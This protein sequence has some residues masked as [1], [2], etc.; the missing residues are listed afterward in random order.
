MAFKS[1]VKDTFGLLA[2][3][4]HTTFLM[5]NRWNLI[6]LLSV[7]SAVLSGEGDDRARGVDVLFRLG[8]MPQSRAGNLHVRTSSPSAPHTTLPSSSNLP[9]PGYGVMLDS[10][11]LYEASTKSLIPSEIGEDFSFV[12]S[13]SSWRANNAFLF[14]I[15]DGRD[16][17]R[18]GVQLLPRRVVVH[19]AE[20][21][22]YF[23]YNWQDG[24][25][26]ALGVRAHSV[27]FYAECGAVQQR[28]QT[29]R[30]AQML[31]ESG[32]LFTLGRMN[33]KSPAFSGRLCQLDIYPS[34]QAAA[35]YCNY[36]KTQCR[37]ADTYRL[38]HPGLNMEA[39][40]P[41]FDPLPHPEDQTS[42]AI[43][44]P[45]STTSMLLPGT[46]PTLSPKGGLDPTRS[47]TTKIVWMK[48]KSPDKEADPAEE[49]SSSG[50]LQATEVALDPIPSVKQSQ[51]REGTKSSTMTPQ[52]TP[53]LDIPHEAKRH[54]F[55]PRGPGGQTTRRGREL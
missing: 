8:L 24:G 13:L 33:S 22:V 49:E 9:V 27:S 35:H 38:P 23:T 44:Y 51:A 5:G 3:E 10:N 48:R 12:V 28:A 20:N 53:Q 55:V 25:P 47:T 31:R 43:L 14:S 42:M 30:R 21:T 37:R 1:P 29:L 54:H 2:V 26:F 52:Q 46:L 45:H 32:G 36:L 4:C 6:L 18:F 50:S 16:R 7:C 15:K 41:P 11:A 17:L 40:D 39:N 19:T 34:A